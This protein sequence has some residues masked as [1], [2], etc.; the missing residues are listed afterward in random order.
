[1]KSLLIAVLLIALQVNPVLAHQYSVKFSEIAWMG[2]N[3]SSSDEWLEL[4]NSSSE[5][6]SL[7]GWGIYES[8]GE[9]LVED[10]HGE[11]GGGSFYLVERTNNDTVSDISASQE[12]SGWGGGGL[13]ND[14]E[15][16]VIKDNE[17]N[18]VDRVDASEGWFA[19]SNTTKTSME[20]VDYSSA[21]SS[22][23]QESSGTVGKDAEGNPIYGTPG[24][25]NSS[26]VVN[27]D[28]GEEEEIEAES[29]EDDEADTEASSETL[30]LNELMPNPTGDDSAEYI[31]LFN[32]GNEVVKLVGWA[33]GDES[34]TKRLDAIT[35]EQKCAAGDYLVLYRSQG[36]I[37]LNNDGDKVYLFGPGGE[38]VDEVSYQDVAEGQAYAYDGFSWLVSLAPTPGQVNEMV[39]EEEEETN[40]LNEESE[41]EAAKDEVTTTTVAKPTVKAKVVQPAS[42]DNIELLTHDLVKGAQTYQIGDKPPTNEKLSTK[43][44]MILT[45]FLVGI[46]GALGYLKWREKR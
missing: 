19:G 34:S 44:V 17:G 26:G 4:Y 18:I 29:E 16:L 25:A 31:E 13:A 7:E 46:V 40:T 33:I 28:E 37:S 11:I 12:P 24:K 43:R 42:W 41:R 3:A 14:G 1:M 38:V 10:L 27:Q 23:W 9:V 6:V 5:T 36:S 45:V 22:A 2:T 39:F 20:R 8:G 15:D 35:A 21:E 32:Y 30:R